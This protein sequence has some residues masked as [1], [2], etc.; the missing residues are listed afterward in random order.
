MGR[1]QSYAPRASTEAAKV[2]PVYGST[3]GKRGSCSEEGR[4]RNEVEGASRCLTPSSL[5]PT[6]AH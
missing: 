2:N 4:F 3:G 5:S 6:S 1:K